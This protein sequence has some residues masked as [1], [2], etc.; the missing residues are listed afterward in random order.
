MAVIPSISTAGHYEEI[1]CLGRVLSR[2]DKGIHLR[3]PNSCI[4]EMVD[5][6]LRHGTAIG[7]TGT[8]TPTKKDG[9]TSHLDYESHRVYR[10]IV[11]DLLWLVPICHDLSYVFNELGRTV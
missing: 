5:L 4:T 6:G 7:T 11:G 3:A 10:R 8:T 1:P 2:D 9:E